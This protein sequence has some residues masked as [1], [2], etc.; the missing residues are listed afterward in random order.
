M[1]ELCFIPEFLRLELNKFSKI[2]KPMKNKLI[3]LLD[4]LA[5]R[6]LIKSTVKYVGLGAKVS[7][8]KITAKKNCQLE[9]GNNSIVEASVFFDKDDA[10]IVIGDRTFIGASTVVCAK[11]I[12]IGSD[13]LIS[14]GC[15]IVDHDS[16]SVIFNNRSKDVQKWFHGL[17]DW[18]DVKVASVMI[19]DKAWLGF[20]VIVLKGVTIGEGAV[21]GAGSVVTKD[22]PPYTINVGN[23]AHVI[24]DIPQDER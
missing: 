13:V 6:R 7:F 9:I 16:H 4:F 15:T 14:W 19:N 12:I 3:K 8:R 1:K 22:V 5:Y 21:I 20:N 11:N 23:P 2:K 10:K 17:K 18:N 24:R